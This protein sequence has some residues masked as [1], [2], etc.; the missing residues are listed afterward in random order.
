MK[1]I[2]LVLLAASALSLPLFAKDDNYDDL[3]S[4]AKQFLNEKG[5]SSAASKVENAVAEPPRSRFIDTAPK[6]ATE[7]DKRHVMV[8]MKL[9]NR[10]FSKKNYEKAIE[11]VNSVFTRDPANAGGHFMLAVIAGRQKDYK[12]AWY[13]IDVAK[14][15]D[16]SNKKIDDF[17]AKL[18]TVS[19]K[20]ESEWIPGVYNGSPVDASE[21][22]FDLLE[23][24]L[25]DECSQNICSVEVTDYT[26]DG[27]NV[28]LEASFNSLDPIPTEKI[29]SLLKQKNGSGVS[30]ISST[31]KSLKVK[32]T[33]NNASPENPKVSPIKGLNDFINDLTEEMPEIAVNNTEEAE[34]AGGTQEIIYDIS[35]RE[36]STVNKFFRHISPFAT[37]YMLQM[38][39]LS[40]IPGSQSATIWKARIKVIYKI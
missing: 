34:P 27:N 9:A 18:K 24:L 5:K 33:Y 22:T 16:S 19:Q 13:H 4:K 36:F 37:K 25:S 23:S 35:S 10:H 1:K 31:D 28:T 29:V 15:K 39:T 8:H 7:E 12:S 38:M 17:I 20:P 2:A 21:R 6:S 32:L 3:K 11:E 26:K 14:E 40:Y 30:E